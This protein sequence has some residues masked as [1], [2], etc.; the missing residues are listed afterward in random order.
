MAAAMAEHDRTFDGSP[1]A[2]QALQLQGNISEYVEVHMEQGPVL[3]GLGKPVGAVSGIAAQL[4]F[5]VE[6]RGEQGHAGE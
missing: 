5:R 6:L 3:E 2:L 1:A 4:R